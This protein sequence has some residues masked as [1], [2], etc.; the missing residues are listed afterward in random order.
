[1]KLHSLI[2]VM[3]ARLQMD[4][5]SCIDAYLELSKEALRVADTESTSLVE[6][7]MPGVPR[8]ALSPKSSRPRSFNS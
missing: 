4:V 5:K 7:L 3:L 6:Q 8:S 1:M 2:A